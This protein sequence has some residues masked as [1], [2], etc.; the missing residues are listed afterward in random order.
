M[1]SATITVSEEEIRKRLGNLADKSGLV[2]SRAANRSINTGKKAL[3]QETAKIYNVKQRDV[4]GILRVRRAT[5]ARPSVSMTFKDYHRNLYAFGNNDTVT[6][7]YT[8]RSSDPYDPDPGYLRVKVKKGKSIPMKGRRKPFVQIS[9]KNGYV[10]VF[11]RVSDGK[12]SPLRT[13]SAPAMPQI[14]KNEE[15]IA[16]FNRDAYSMF[17]KRL[18]HEI[19]QVLKGANS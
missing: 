9:P 19:G 10:L 15:V 6:P 18:N 1:I 4:E 11:Q 12:N 2:I 3:K 13:I 14:L 17:S 7:R 8:V 16:R 5:P